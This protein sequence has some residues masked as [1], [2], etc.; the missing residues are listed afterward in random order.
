MLDLTSLT[1]DEFEQLVPVVEAAFVAH[2]QDWTIDGHPRTGR[3]S[4][5]YANC[6][7]PTAE[8]RLLFLVI[9]LKSGTLQVT[10][11]ALFG[12]SQPNASRWTGRG[13]STAIQTQFLRRLYLWL[14][15]SYASNCSPARISSK[16]HRSPPV[17]PSSS[18]TSSKRITLS[19]VKDGSA[20]N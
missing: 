7:L 13:L 17:P 14:C 12:L 6:P 2:M 11:G 8:D 15:F 3:R 19:G 18:C 4:S 5:T 16:I 9:S 20:A 1:V 10:H